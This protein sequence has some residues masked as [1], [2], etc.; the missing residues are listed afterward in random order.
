[1]LAGDRKMNKI[2][3]KLAEMNAK[4]AALDA[5]SIMASLVD[6]GA[7]P[8]EK[9]YHD[10]ED[11][12]GKQKEKRL[13]LRHPFLTGIPTLGIAPAIARSKASKE[14][15]MLL[16]ARH[17]EMHQQIVDYWDKMYERGVQQ[18][19]QQT[20]S[21][22]ANVIPNAAVPVAASIAAAIMARRQRNGRDE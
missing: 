14:I 16:K 7:I 1:M 21:D 13:A 12:L 5:A 8:T 3:H 11:M 10:A 6:Q 15:T 9:A 19:Q 22:R 18:Q 4:E 20:E 17:P 2:A